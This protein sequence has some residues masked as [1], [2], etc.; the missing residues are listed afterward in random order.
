MAY[1]GSLVFD[2]KIDASGFKKGLSKISAI[3]AGVTKS[4]LGAGAAMTAIGGYAFKVGSD[5]KAAMSEVQAIS[6]ATGE[7]LKKLTKK[8]E[9]MGAK[10]KFSATESAEALKYMAMAGWD[11]NKMLAALPG[12]MNLAAASGENLGTVS[13]IVTDAMTAFNLKADQAGHF[14]DILAMASSKSNTNVSM[15]GESFKY[16][17]PLC[18]ALGYSAE[19]TALALGLMANAGVK[20]SI[21]GTSLKAS[22]A[23]LTKPTKRMRAAMSDLGISLTD[24]QGQ[25]KPLKQLLD[26]MRTS[27]RGLRKDQQAAY[28]TTLFGKEAMAGMLAI[29]NASDDDYNKLANS[30]RNCNGAADEMRRIM[31]DNLKG[32]ITSLNSAVEGLGISAYNYLDKP[33]RGAAQ[34]LKGYVNEL[35][36]S[37]K[38]ADDLRQEMLDAGA[39]MGEVNAELASMDTSK[40]VGGFEGLSAKIGE[41]LSNIVSNIATST[42]KFIKLGTTVIKNLLQGLNDNMPGITKS[43]SDGMT[44]L[45]K[46][47]ADIIPLFLDTG[48]KFLLGL[49]NGILNNLPTITASLGT[50]I[51]NIANFLVANIPL[52]INMGVSLLTALVNGFS[53]NP[54]T[55]VTTIITLVNTLATS[56]TENIP[57]IVNC[58]I[59]LITALAQGI[60]DN[61]PLLIETVPKIINDFA[62]AIYNQGPKILKAAL[63]IIIILGKGLI[64]AIPTLIKNIP[65]IILAIVNV[66]T[67]FNWA[68]LGTNMI[69]GIKN[70]AIALKNNIVE[71]IKG[72]GSNIVAG[73]RY[74]LSGDGI[75]SIGSNFLNLIKNGFLSFKDAIFNTI[76]G[77]AT[78]VID[79]V[80]GIFGSGSIPEIGLNLIKGIGNGILKAKDWIFNI[81]KNF[82]AAVIDK[83]KS[84]FGIHSPSVI[85]RDE[86]GKNIVKGI[87]VGIK[88]EQKNLNDVIVKMSEMAID[89]AK[90]EAKDYK[91]IGKIYAEN[92]SKGFEVEY[93]RSVSEFNKTIDSTIKK[94]I[95]E[96]EKQKMIKKTGGKRNENSEYNSKVTETNKEIDRQIKAYK[97]AGKQ[98]G[99][100][101]EDSL[102][103]SFEIAEKTISEEMQKITEEASMQYDEIMRKK[104]EMEKKLA[105]FGELFSI[106]K[107]S[108]E[109]VLSNINDQI[110]AIQKYDEVL[111]AL[112]NKG[113]SEGLLSE[114]TKMG[115]ED[116]TKYGEQLLKLTDNQ[117]KAYQDSWLKK[118]KLAKEVAAKFYKDQLDALQNDMVNKLDATLKNVPNVTK[119]VG[120]DSMKGMIAGMDSMKSSA[121][122][123]AREIA[124]AIIAEM[125]RALDIH[126]PSRVMRNLIGK[127]IV[128]GIEVGIDDEKSNLLRK[129][130]SVVGMASKEMTLNTKANSGLASKSSVITN[131]NDNGV[132]QEINIYQPVKSPLEMM[133]EA[134][135]TAK[136]LAYAN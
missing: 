129:M 127:N 37:M 29:I 93:K 32:D 28:A 103:T 6:G 81:I 26:E 34:T 7:D 19:D 16:V 135:R 90:K 8:A 89:T 62:S 68:K 63:D 4:I 98:V 92:I 74:V 123:K 114:I 51:G 61:L 64:A 136:E 79:T 47:L 13:D 44:E 45:V 46:G 73:V 58:G 105:D 2:T 110:S 22:I 65:Q 53:A 78:G 82:G 95:A 126:S 102:K 116:G 85:M 76:K 17:A 96:L 41:I 91:D 107:E 130:K 99:K 113:A 86:V 10:T 56:I 42:P 36:Q 100:A 39:S 132:K 106:D 21:A 50:M 125:Q 38:S 134:K 30:I 48:A 111:T 122:G 109:V 88:Q 23:N 104:E 84:V 120:I 59:T 57:N 67:L 115:I 24:A 5:F 33:F 54:A 133:R 18:G 14:A 87:A 40:M 77:I 94:Q 112:K 3:G 43:L 108:K 70:G 31:E 60:A 27:M 97:D 15:L 55:F 128:R 9:E 83:I 75:R 49:G 25:M 121:V 1:D 117:F 72:I 119:T 11:T 35:N 66:F 20:S 101:Y 71:A 52:F 131:N 118:Q 12:V 80:K 69:N 124:D